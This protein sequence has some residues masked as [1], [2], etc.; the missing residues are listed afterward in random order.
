MERTREG[1][2]GGEREGGRPGKHAVIFKVMLDLVEIERHRGRA[3]NKN[4]EQSPTS[5]Q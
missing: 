4:P 2:A 3:D 1:G 5:Y